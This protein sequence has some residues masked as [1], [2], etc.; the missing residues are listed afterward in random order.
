MLNTITIHF[1][2]NFSLLILNITFT[3]TFLVLWVLGHQKNMCSYISLFK[4]FQIYQSI[5][6]I[7][8]EKVL[9]KNKIIL[10]TL[11]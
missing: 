8:T 3:I 7:F 9:Y 10:L 11:V 5:L 4:K 2:C 1:I 6:M